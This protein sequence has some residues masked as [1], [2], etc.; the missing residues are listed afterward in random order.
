MDWLGDLDVHTIIDRK[1]PE[2]NHIDNPKIFLEGLEAMLLG[3]RHA[4]TMDDQLESGY[5][6]ANGK[7]CPRERWSVIQFSFADNLPRQTMH[8]GGQLSSEFPV[9]KE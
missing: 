5:T 1:H 3:K 4:S 6:L 2:T 7:Q 9:E 8:G